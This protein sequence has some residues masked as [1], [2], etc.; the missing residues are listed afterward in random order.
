MSFIQDVYHHAKIAS[1]KRHPH[2][3]VRQSQASFHWTRMGKSS[4][5]FVVKR[6][7]GLETFAFS[8]FFAIVFTES[9]YAWQVIAKYTKIQQDSH[10]K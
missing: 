4:K 7:N 6:D 9:P 8:K 3:D 2:A 10:M 5:Q 1:F